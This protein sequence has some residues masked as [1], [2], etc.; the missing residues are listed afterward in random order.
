VALL[1]VLLAP[2]ACVNLEEPWIKARSHRGTGGAAGLGAGGATDQGPELDG[3]GNGPDPEGMAGALDG[4]LPG[5]DGEQV[6]P[7]NEVAA[8]G[9]TTGSFDAW[10]DDLDGGAA[11]DGDSDAAGADTSRRPDTPADGPSDAP[12]DLHGDLTDAATDGLTSLGLLAYYA[13]EDPDGTAGTTLTDG[14]GNDNHGRLAVGPLPS[15]STPPDAGSAWGF[16]PGKVGAGLVL[17][18]QA[19]GHVALPAGLLAGQK[20]ATFAAWIKITSTTPYQRVFDFSADS[21]NYMYLATNSR[22][23]GPRF[24][25]VKAG[26]SQ[27][28]EA[29][30][31]LAT[32]TWTHLALVL[33]ADGA[34]IYVDGERQARSRDITF[35]PDD[36]GSTANDFIGRSANATDVYLDGAIDEYRIYARAL[37]SEEIAALAGK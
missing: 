21:S 13:C 24:R 6:L 37:G 36:L 30:R 7:A 19:Y 15:G 16:E 28:L 11:G 8:T 3:S 25:I 5:V 33:G 18:G 2:S 17:H 22:S 26:S 34:A 32:N 23:S 29:S 31:T 20:E 35:R 27:T 9:G 10:F 14:S 4:A 12:D 1:V